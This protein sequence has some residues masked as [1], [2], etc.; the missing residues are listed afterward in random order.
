MSAQPAPVPRPQPDLAARIAALRAMLTDAID[1]AGMRNDPYQP[2]LQ[3][4]LSVVGLLAEATENLDQNR[5]LITPEERRTF[6]A[7]TA[8]QTAVAMV[9]HASQVVSAAKWQAWALISGMTLI[10]LLTGF[11]GGFWYKYSTTVIP[12]PPPALECVA[13]R[14]GSYCGYWQ[15][16][17]TEPEPAAIPSPTPARRSVR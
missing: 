7:Q 9:A 8:R 17:P 14:G 6:I 2:V 13:N 1:K 16:P 4:T 12:E 10:A 15:S 11:G 3:A 5:V